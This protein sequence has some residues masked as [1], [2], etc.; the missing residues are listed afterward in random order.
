MLRNKYLLSI[1]PIFAEQILS[2]EKEWELRR[3]S[4]I[5]PWSIVFLY[6]SRPISSI[7]G[8]ALIGDTSFLESLEVE[9]LIRKGSLKGCNELDIPYVK[10]KSRVELLRIVS[11]LRY[12]RRIGLK[13]LYEMGIRVP[14]SYAKAA[15]LLIDM[16][17]PIR[18]ESARKYLYC[19]VFVAGNHVY[20]RNILDAIR[21]VGVKYRVLRAE[22]LSNVYSRVVCSFQFR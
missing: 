2:C 17:N 12:T 4:K 5:K 19:L 21:K 1:K 13:D 20:R 22:N 3:R 16:L 6:A 10:G 11:A 18:V 15:K 9:R 7:V 8:E 14:V